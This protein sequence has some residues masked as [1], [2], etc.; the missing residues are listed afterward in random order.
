MKADFMLSPPWD[1][2]LH[3][4]ELQVSKILWRKIDL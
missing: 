1:A 2:E 4:E 3:G